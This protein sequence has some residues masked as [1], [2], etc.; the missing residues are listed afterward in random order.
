MKR[1]GLLGFGSI[2]KYVYEKMANED[3]IVIEFVVDPFVKENEHSI[4]ILNELPHNLEG[5]DLVVEVANADVV[6]ANGLRILKN[7]NFMPF[8]VTAFSD[9]DFLREA[10]KASNENKNNIYIPHGA[11]LGLD[12]IVDGKGI[13]KN[14]SITTTKKPEGFGRNDETKTTIFEG[15]TRGAC[16]SYPK[17]VNV[18]GGIALAGLG[19]TNTKSKIIADPDIDGNTHI[20]LVEGEGTEFEIKVKSIPK[21]KVSG[22]YTAESAFGSIKRVLLEEGGIKFV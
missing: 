21:G 12:G 3:N 19:F 2:G 13:L 4:N 8:S 5:I 17:N 15:N 7:T 10:L 6:K 11:I 18:H 20:I 9:E 22:R 16:Q 1:I 14:I